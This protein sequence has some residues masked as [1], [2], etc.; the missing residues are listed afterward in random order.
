MKLNPWA[1]LVLRMRADES[2]SRTQQILEEKA[3]RLNLSV[4]ELEQKL[5][6]QNGFDFEREREEL[7][8]GFVEDGDDGE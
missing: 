6:E 7:E 3:K 1:K 2:W 8:D 5:L 4:E